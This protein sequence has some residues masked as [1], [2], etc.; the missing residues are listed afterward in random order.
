MSSAA[1]SAAHV[2]W[3]EEVDSEGFADLAEGVSD[4]LDDDGVPADD[5]PE[6]KALGAADDRA[7][8]LVTRR[9]PLP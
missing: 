6:P 3:I 4:L 1:G 5:D 8:W 2:L 9:L 7:A